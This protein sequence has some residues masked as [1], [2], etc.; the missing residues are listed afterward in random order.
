MPGV[1]KASSRRLGPTKA[2]IVIIVVVGIPV[3]VALLVCLLGSAT[4]TLRTCGS[5]SP[6]VRGTTVDHAVA[7]PSI[8]PGSLLVQ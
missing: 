2:T 1:A 4:V 6:T 3:P 7:L 5:A 8:L